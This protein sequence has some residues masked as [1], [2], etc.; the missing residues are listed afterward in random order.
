MMAEENSKTDADDDDT[1][2]NPVDE[3]SAAEEASDAANN[4]DT[5][6]DITAADE[7]ADD[8]GMAEEKNDVASPSSGES[9]NEPAI[10]N[11]IPVVQQTRVSAADG[12]EIVEPIAD[13]SMLLDIPVTLSMEIGQTRISINELL[14]LGKDSVIELQRMAH[15]P[16]DVLVNGTLVAHGEAVVI[17]DRFGIRL[18]DVISPQE[19]LRKFG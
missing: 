11:E 17:G 1:S 7:T 16:L 9:A 14:K 18:T 15:E 8:Q 12:S 2:V 10:G 3:A 13:I 5:P 6:D 19:R 4:T